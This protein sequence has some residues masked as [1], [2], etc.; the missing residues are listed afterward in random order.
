MNDYLS[1]IG[2]ARTDDFINALLQQ[3]NKE[4]SQNTPGHKNDPS[5]KKRGSYLLWSG[6]L[7]ITVGVLDLYTGNRI[8]FMPFYLI[9]IAMAG[10]CAG[11]P[12]GIIMAIASGLM[13][14]LADISAAPGSA[15][16]IAPYWNAIVRVGFFLIAAFL[17]R[18]F[19]DLHA[20]REQARTDHLTGLANRRCFYDIAGREID[21]SRRYGH[22]LSLVFLDCDN[23]KKINDHFGHQTG[24]EVIRA[25]GEVIKAN[26]R[27]SDL[28]ARLGGDEFVVLLPETG[29]DNVHDFVD[30]LNKSIPHIG[31]I[32][33]W[34]TTV[35]IGAVSYKVP[36]DSVDQMITQAD[37]LM[38]NAKSNDRDHRMEF[39]CH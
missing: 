27:Q 18:L 36:P 12:W 26:T 2:F 30:R 35:S 19:H 9:P 16:E 5:R 31:S 33:G 29:C 23:F 25:M 10:V 28:V 7:L 11:R 37:E 1:I 38:Y 13:W 17:I 24:D 4:Q 15:G 21:R 22:P 32:Y 6:V 34:S 20:E 8:S 3:S 14:L 39:I